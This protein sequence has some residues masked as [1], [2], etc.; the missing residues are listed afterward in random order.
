MKKV[1][2]FFRDYPYIA[3]PVIG[4]ILSFIIR[5]GD[6]NLFVW[7]FV[8]VAVI[9][10]AFANK[11]RK[12]REHLEF[13]RLQAR[14]F[15]ESIKKNKSLSPIPAP[16]FLAPDEH[17]F[18]QDGNSGL[19]ETRAV[20]H[21]TGGFGSVRVARGVRIGGYSGRSESFQ[22]WRKLDKGQLLLTNEKVLFMGSKENRTFA[23]SKIIAINTL[24][25]AVRL[26]IDGRSKDVMF[27]VGNPYI[28]CAALNILKSTKTPLDLSHVNINITFE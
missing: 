21:S 5:R 4:I 26:S 11:R 24:K 25:D 18:L 16:I 17:L 12:D 9:S 8:I 28:W 2:W 19:L 15:V 7:I 20:R 6:I 10:Q 23:V 1:K 14:E 3:Y 22:E 13:L 27:P